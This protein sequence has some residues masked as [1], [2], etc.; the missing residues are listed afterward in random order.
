MDT[1]LYCGMQVKCIPTNFPKKVMLSITILIGLGEGGSTMKYFQRIKS[2]EQLLL[3]VGL[4][5]GNNKEKCL[6]KIT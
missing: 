4:I 5:K 2:F 1:L 6:C 3:P